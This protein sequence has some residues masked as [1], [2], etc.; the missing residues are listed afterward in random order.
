V[1][2]ALHIAAAKGLSDVVTSLVDRGANVLAEDKQ[3]E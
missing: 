2:R 3:G 1:F